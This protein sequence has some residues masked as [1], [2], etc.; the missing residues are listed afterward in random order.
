MI[1]NESIWLC[2][3]E[4]Q[5]S[6]EDIS[7]RE[8]V[9]ADV[10]FKPWQNDKSKFAL[11]DLIEIP[12]ENSFTVFEPILDNEPSKYTLLPSILPVITFPFDISVPKPSVIF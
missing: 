5:F 2:K 1:A 3:L 9:I 8:I 7:I 6:R 12:L 10:D 11:V 4:L